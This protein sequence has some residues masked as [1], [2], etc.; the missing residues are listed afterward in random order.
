MA[1]RLQLMTHKETGDLLVFDVNTE[2]GR[3]ELAKVIEA[4]T[5]RQGPVLLYTPGEGT[6]RGEAWI[7][8]YC[9]KLEE[10][11]TIKIHACET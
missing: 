7:D 9:C 5:A 11:V 1:T 8:L 10:D 3:T 2:F 4:G 6:T